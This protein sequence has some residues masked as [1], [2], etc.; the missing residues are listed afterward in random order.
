MHE[1]HITL[2]LVTDKALTENDQG[3]LRG[4]IKQVVDDFA[5]LPL[6]ADLVGSEIKYVA[7]MP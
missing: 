6:D 5:S 2:I 4:E 7:R 3:T 1:Y